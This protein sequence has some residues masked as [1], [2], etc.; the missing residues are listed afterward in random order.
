MI[1][2]SVYLSEDE[3]AA[4]RRLATTSGQ[5]QADLIRE[6]VRRV[7]GDEPAR[8]FKS[9]ASGSGPAYSP[10][11]ADEIEAHVNGVR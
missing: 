8:R 2:T 1:K 3:A 4:L 5:S 6:G 9:R 11:T 10:P 7:T